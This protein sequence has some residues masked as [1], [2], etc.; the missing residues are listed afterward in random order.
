MNHPS[1]ECPRLRAR[2]PS[3]WC[4][5]YNKWGN[6]ETSQCKYPRILPH[7][8]TQTYQPRPQQLASLAPPLQSNQFV[9]GANNFRTMPYQPQNVPLLPPI[10][11]PQ[12]PPPRITPM[13]QVM[14]EDMPQGWSEPVGVNPILN[15][16]RCML[17]NRL[18]RKRMT[19][20]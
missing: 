5:H 14:V 10:L 4:G 9:Q 16:P 7:A 19:N 8:Q 13:N 3:M 6:L 15:S 11:G 2:L 20:I 12:P 17:N 1:N 18:P